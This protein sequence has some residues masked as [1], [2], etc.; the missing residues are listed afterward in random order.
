MS[1][2]KKMF[3][4]R[5]FDELKQSADTLFETGDFGAAKIEYERAK[6]RSKQA[7]DDARNHVLTRI[8]TCRDKLAEKR[9]DKA[10]DFLRTDQLALAVS[11][12]ENAIE[13]AASDEVIQRANK[14]IEEAEREEIQEDQIQPESQT[15]EERYAIIAGSWEEEQSEEYEN[16]GSEFV[17][18]LLALDD[19]QVQQARERLEDLLQRAE[20]PHYLYFEVGKVRLL[21]GDLEKGAEAM[22]QFLTRIG[23]DE[24]GGMRLAAHTELARLANEANDFEG[25]V[26]QLQAAIEAMPKDPRPYLV[27]GNF[28]RQ[29]GHLEEATA[30][31][32]S[33]LNMMVACDVHPD[34][35]I[36]QELGLTFA[37]LE[38]PQ[39]AIEYLEQVVSILVARQHLDLPPQAATRLAELHEQSGN[40]ARAAD[41]YSMLAHG[42]DTENYFLYYKESGRLLA[43]IGVKVEARRALQ[44]AIDLAPDDEQAKEALRLQLEA[45]KE[46]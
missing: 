41:L 33:G 26:A 13:I 32:E 8:N 18:A 30:V 27:M 45:L 23:P 21:D 20:D 6:E 43:E 36:I 5:S 28:L 12:L 9:I 35:R 31:L 39:K 14:M 17:D 2:I 46:A 44:R 1:L 38:N 24:G 4:L 22:R 7:S 19:N 25:A 15:D 42:S 34:W 10:L 29:Q 16:Y 37:D 3:G 40:K 11:E